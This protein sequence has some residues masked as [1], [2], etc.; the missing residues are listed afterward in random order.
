MK[1]FII[2]VFS[3]F[4]LYSF[5]PYDCSKEKRGFCSIKYKEVVKSQVGKVKGKIMCKM[6]DLKMSKMCQK[7]L[8][9]EDQKIY[10]FCSCSKK[11]EEVEKL[12]DKEVEVTGKIC[13]MKDGTTQIHSESIKVL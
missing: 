13:F 12:N 3:I 1:K 8:Y 6:S 7:V 11:N 5:K 2:F 9:T 4:F 10:E